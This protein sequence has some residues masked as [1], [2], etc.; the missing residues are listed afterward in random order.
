MKKSVFYFL[1]NATII[2]FSKILDTAN[3]SITTKL[4]RDNFSIDDFEMVAKALGYEF[5]RDFV[6]KN[7]DK[8]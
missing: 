8:I 4:S 5:E 6:N 2:E 7:G 3:Q 1:K